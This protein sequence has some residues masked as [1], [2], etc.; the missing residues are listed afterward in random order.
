MWNCALE[1]VTHA[2]TGAAATRR[3]VRQW[4]IMLFVGSPV[5]RYRIAPQRQPPSTIVV[6]MALSARLHVGSSGMA[7]KT[8]PHHFVALAAF[9]IRRATAAGCETYT[10]W[11]PATSSTVAPARWDVKRCA[12]GGI[13]RSAAATNDA[14]CMAVFA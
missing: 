5:T 7:M 3:Q 2:T 9:A 10:A 6:V 1:N 11:L 8:A 14:H 12:G 4:Q 13:I